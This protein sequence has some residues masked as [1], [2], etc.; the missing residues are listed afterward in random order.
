MYDI[1]K[2]IEC[3][4]LTV[5]KLIEHLQTVN[6]DARVYFNGDNYGYI[7]IEKDSSVIS[8]DNSS[9]DD[10]YYYDEL[11][12]FLD[13]G[14]ERWRNERKEGCPGPG[15]ENVYGQWV[16]KKDHSNYENAVFN[17]ECK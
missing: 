2:R 1:N 8:F 5:G 11:K 6:K 17:G 7:H 12:E 9:L 15:Y 3:K 14:L 13:K 10:D 16:P 4:N